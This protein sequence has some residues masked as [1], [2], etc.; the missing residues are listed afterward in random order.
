LPVNLEQVKTLT[1]LE[2]MLYWVCERHEVYLRR[3]AGLPKPWTDDEILRSYYFT[4]PFR[5][6]D[7]TTAWLRENVRDPLRDSPSVLGA[8]VAFRWFNAIS[9]GQLLLK[10]GLLH[11]WDAARAYQLLHE[12]WQ[13]GN[14]EKVFT[15][16]YMIKAGNGPPGCK[17]AS[18]CRAITKVVNG[19]QSVLEACAQRPVR[20]ENAWRVLTRFPYMGGFM[21]YEVVCDLR[22]TALLREAIDVDTW[23][24][25]GPGAKRGMNRLLGRPLEAPISKVTWQDNTR[26]LLDRF[27]ELKLRDAP[28]PEMRE[29][30]HVLC[31]VDKYNRALFG[32][33]RLKR[34]YDGR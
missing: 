26:S 25:V 10:H 19:Q 8:V 20:M 28:V 14:G 5:E 7:K 13:G 21:A 3:K 30:E 9:T 22:Y 4:N 24:N 18:V 15:G 1:P 16:A 34:R 2:R 31:E 11:K 6:H 27:K 32:Q 12:R 23:C 29:V 33:G 17:I